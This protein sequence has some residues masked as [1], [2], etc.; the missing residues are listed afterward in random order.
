MR[1]QS[2]VPAAAAAVLIAVTVV[3]A[4]GGWYL[5]C[6]DADGNTLSGIDCLQDHPVPRSDA[7]VVGALG[8]VPLA[9]LWCVSAAVL[10]GSLWAR[11][12]RKN[13]SG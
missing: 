9:V 12:R 7:A 5:T 3:F 6:R 13:A 10:L 4:L 11:S 2:A 1:W 8:F